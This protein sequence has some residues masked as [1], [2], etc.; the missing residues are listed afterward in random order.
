MPEKQTT[1]SKSGKEPSVILRSIWAS[2]VAHQLKKKK[3]KNLPANVGSIP[4]LERSPG[5]GNGNPLQYFCLGNPGERSLV[6]YSLWGCKKS[7]KHTQS[8]TQSLHSSFQISFPQENHLKV[9]R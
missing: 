9:H 7:T 6:G 8:H 5:E 4:R 1:Q 2:L 3:K